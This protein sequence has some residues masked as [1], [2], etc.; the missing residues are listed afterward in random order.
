ME[1]MWCVAVAGVQVW[2][3]VVLFLIMLPAMFGLSLGVTGFYIRVLVRLL[4]VGEA[5][6]LSSALGIRAEL[7]QNVTVCS[8]PRCG[9]RGDRGRSLAD[10]VPCPAVSPVKHDQ[11]RTTEDEENI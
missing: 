3:F 1:D 11:S 7:T 2:L 8:G 9:S 5:L 6:W 10:R 4:E